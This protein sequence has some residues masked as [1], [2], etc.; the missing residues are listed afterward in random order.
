MQV[1]FCCGFDISCKGAVGF[2]KHTVQQIKCVVSFKHLIS[3]AKLTV[4]Q[5]MQNVFLRVTLF[6]WLPLHLVK[7]CRLNKGVIS[8]K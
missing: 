5:C 7:W 6:N 1:T 2:P 3:S 8:F 4:L